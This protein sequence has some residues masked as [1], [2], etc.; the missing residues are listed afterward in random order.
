MSISG[1]ALSWIIEGIII[2][3]VIRFIIGLLPRNVM[4]R[5]EEKQMHKQREDNQRQLIQE[6]INAIENKA[7]DFDKI[8]IKSYIYTGD[9]ADT[10]YYKYLNRS[11]GGVT[12]ASGEKNFYYA[13][14]SHGYAVSPATA[15]ALADAIVKRFGGEYNGRNTS[16]SEDNRLSAEITILSARL[17]NAERDYRSNMRRC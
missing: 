10:L 9:C 3:F 13:F 2:F 4:S 11:G 6:I 5:K 17:I 14:D 15:F 1:S 16:K 8:E 7:P 12:I